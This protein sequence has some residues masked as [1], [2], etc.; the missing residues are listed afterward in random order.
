MTRK[1]NEIF[2]SL[3]GEGAN[4]G[5]PSVFVRFSGCNLR[6]PF[7]DTS[8]QHGREI[9]DAEIIADVAR[10]HAPL[11]ILTGG[12]PSLWIDSEFVSAL[13]EGTG[14]R[15]CIETN[16]TRPLPEGLD[17]VTVSPKSGICGS[18]G[19]DLPILAQHADEIKVVDL[20][21]PLDPYFRLACR[22]EDTLMYLQPCHVE[23]AAV[24]EANLRRTVQRVLD[25]PR[26][27]LSLQTHRMIDIP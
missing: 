26:W 20:G 11:T 5:V 19:G 13:K 18:D 2:Y 22:R 16:G 1:I 9:T 23:D 4:T 21:Q 15:I 24:A 25:D 14:S 17:W 10:H 12:E 8:H 27:R 6:C 7:C 3:Q